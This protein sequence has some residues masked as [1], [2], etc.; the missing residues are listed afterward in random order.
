[1]IER[2]PARPALLV[3]G[4]PA[5]GKTTCARRLAA[6][7][8]HCAVVDVDDIRQLVVAGHAAP[9]DGA[10]GAAQHRLGAENACRLARSFDA[11]GLDIVLTDV[12]TGAVWPV[13]AEQLPAAVIVH[14]RISAAE[15]HR[16]LESRPRRLS[17]A[18]FLRLWQDDRETRH[19]GAHELAVDRLTITEQVQA[20]DSLWRRAA[21]R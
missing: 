16:R 1:M 17:H 15:A 3:T 7:R 5:A 20:L 10:E 11:Y 8:P 9:W 18:E 14:L 12:V 6:I 4:P 13:Y 19:P 21:P 2:S